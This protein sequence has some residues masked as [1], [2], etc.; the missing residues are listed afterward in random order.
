M[1]SFQRV[2][3]YEQLYSVEEFVD[4]KRTMLLCDA[5]SL[6]SGLKRNDKRQIAQSLRTLFRNFQESEVA[7][8][9]HDPRCGCRPLSSAVGYLAKREKE[10]EREREREAKSLRAFTATDP[11]APCP[12]RPNRA[13]EHAD[14]QGASFQVPAGTK[15]AA[16]R[17]FSATG[18]LPSV[19]A[20]RKFDARAHALY[21]ARH[22]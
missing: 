18:A 19:G 11:R 20:R 13:P 22:R 15:D 1:A 2:P 17:T 4:L 16:E 10:R 12:G 21:S 5:R 6:P 14:R 7:G 3:R 9:Q 8:C